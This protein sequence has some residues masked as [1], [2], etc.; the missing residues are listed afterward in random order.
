MKF[1]LLL[2]R[3]FGPFQKNVNG[4]KKPYQESTL[5]SKI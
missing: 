5:L 3:R 2:I 4:C 1:F